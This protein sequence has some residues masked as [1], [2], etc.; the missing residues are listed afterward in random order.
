ML[1]NAEK[2]KKRRIQEEMCFKHAKNAEKN[3]FTR[4]IMRFSLNILT[5]FCF[6]ACT[7]YTPEINFVLNISFGEL[8]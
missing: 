7:I 5:V 2:K 4:Y 6:R 8:T 1:K 3:G